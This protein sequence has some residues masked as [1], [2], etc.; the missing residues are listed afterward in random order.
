MG[1]PSLKKPTLLCL[2]LLLISVPAAGG[3]PL[4]LARAAARGEAAGFPVARYGRDARLKT[5]PIGVFDSGIGGLT[6]L[7]SLLSLDS[8]N[9]STHQP[10]ADGR[11]DFEYEKFVYLGDQ[12]NMPYGNYPAEGGVDFLRELVLKDGIFLLGTRFWLNRSAPEPSRDKPPV[13]A[14]VIACN[15]ATAYGLEDLRAAVE[16]WGLPVTVIGVVEAGAKGALEASDGQSA[17]A[18]MAT[19]GTCRS[20]GYVRAVKK[21]FSERNRE[22]PEVVQQGCLGLAGAVEGDASYIDAGG[23]GNQA[24]YRGPAVSNPE[25][26]IDTALIGFYGFD[27]GGLLGEPGD[28]AGWRLNSVENYIRYHCLSLV[29]KYSQTGARLPIGTVILGCT[30]FPYYRQSFIY[31]FERLRKASAPD[32]TAPYRELLAGKINII[33][34]ARLTAEN[35]YLSLKEQKLLLARSEEP[36]VPTDEFYISVPNRD[37]SEVELTPAGAFTYSYKYGRS[38]GR[39]HLEYVKRV[40]ISAA[41]L[42]AA[43]V[44]QIKSGM[45]EVWR[46]LAEFSS[47]SPRCAALA[48]S[49]RFH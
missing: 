17:V 12:A 41:N 40:P 2:V 16:L 5:L 31:N 44:E 26:P 25:V 7:S 14:V 28:P 23:T 27:P 43:A 18:V 21:V 38:P 29:E 46:R 34:P 37:L 42:S 6:V 22:A 4:E 20:E 33:D 32:G 13:K 1:R 11:P 24:D 8:F 3:E 15:T 36:V 47:R 45:P 19:V 49:L 39:V 10:G 35:L 9:N 30:H 48:D